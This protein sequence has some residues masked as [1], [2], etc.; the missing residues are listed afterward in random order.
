MTLQIL[1]TSSSAILGRRESAL[2]RDRLCEPEQEQEQEPE[3]RKTLQGQDVSPTTEINAQSEAAQWPSISTAALE[4]THVLDL[5][6]GSDVDQGLGVSSS[7]G[8]DT[9]P[10]LIR[11]VIDD[12][13]QIV[14]SSKS[15]LQLQRVPNIWSFDYQ[16]GNQSYVGAITACPSSGPTIGLRW[17]ES[18]SPISDHI[19]ILKRLLLGKIK[20][21]NLFDNR[22]C[23]SWV[24]QA[25]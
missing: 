18:N 22:S 21:P 12:I 10:S 24:L 6:F 16:M 19:Q 25:L 1:A 23:E 20:Q 17:V 3:Q 13:G 7:D 9:R 11:D 15:P 8:I 5:A 2:S 14:P 4:S